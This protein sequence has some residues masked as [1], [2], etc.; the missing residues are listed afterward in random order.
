MDDMPRKLPM[1]VVQER[2]RHG[3]VKFY[4]RRFKG[5]R[6]RLPDDLASPE[7]AEA[8]Q[9][10]LAG[11]APLAATAAKTPHTS[12]KWL[13]DRYK[14]SGKWKAYTA[15]TQKQHEN[16]F[17]TVLKNSGNA[18]FADI[19]KKSMEL[20]M[21]DRSHT[22]ALANNFL[23]AMKGLFA[24][25]VKNDHM[26]IN[27]TDGV[28]SFRYKSDG[29]APWTVEDFEKF[30]TKWEIGTKQR[31]AVE[32]LLHSGLRRSDVVNAGRQHMK[33]NIFTMRTI[34]TGATITAEFP[35]H[36]M[37]VIDATETGE[38]AFI[39]SELGKPFTKESF[40]NWFRVQCNEAKVSKSAHG[41][42]KLSATLSAEGG[43][44]AH[45]LM[46]QYGWTNIKQAELYTKGAD[47]KALGIRGSKRIASQLK[48]SS[49]K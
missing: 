6:L 10:A 37:T 47:R 5:P 14:E 45:E 38:L 15:A 32:L 13:I 30:C 48:A 7:F 29:F 17:L 19:D 25:A 36:L 3:K 46:A 40:G 39:V 42:R 20:A 28:E 18:A 23:K 31:L 24:W 27:P 41:V 16:F 2:S 44:P 43:A 22:P 4:F 8:Y 49:S 9:A 26:K 1:H 12:L 21:E 35:D 11:R 34:K 33:G